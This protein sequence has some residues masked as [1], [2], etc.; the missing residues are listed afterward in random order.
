MGGAVCTVCRAGTYLKPENA[1]FSECLLCS[2]GMYSTDGIE[3]IECPQN[4]FSFLGGAT[5][6]MSCPVG[7]HGSRGTNTVRSSLN[8]ACPKCGRGKFVNVPGRSECFNCPPGSS[9]GREGLDESIPCP[10]GRY[11][12]EVNQLQC[13]SC[14]AGRYQNS[15]G[16]AKCLTCRMGKYYNGTGA[17]SSA[18]C[19]LCPQESS[20]TR[21]WHIVVYARG[22]HTTK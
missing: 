13:K 12:D 3:C 10:I 5:A 21:N 18:L 1:T 14:S 11:S 20:G 6:C 19:Q 16:S 22:A 8:E 17:Y 7:R 2:P 15:T 4:T 9:C